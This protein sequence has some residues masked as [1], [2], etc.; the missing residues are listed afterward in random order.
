MKMR[1]SK[2][3][4]L[5]LALLCALLSLYGKPSASTGGGTAD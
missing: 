2:T 5:F 3:K 1:H 4:L